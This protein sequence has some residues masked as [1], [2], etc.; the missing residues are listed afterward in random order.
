M[1]ERTYTKL[2]EKRAEKVISDWGGTLGP[3]LKPFIA[4]ALADERL[5]ER[6][7]CCKAVCMACK[8]GTNPAKKLEGYWVHI[9]PSQ[10]EGMPGTRWSCHAQA[11]RE[12]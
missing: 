12:R 11:I 4:Q 7:E 3:T 9:V 1:M 5:R 8:D 6:E 2:D 10:Y